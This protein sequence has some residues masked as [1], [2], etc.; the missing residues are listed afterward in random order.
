MQELLGYLVGTLII[1][2][3]TASLL[4][5]LVFA[6]PGF[7]GR[8][9]NTLENLPGRAFAVGLVNFIFF[10]LIAAIA[11]QIGDSIGDFVG[12]LFNLSAL[13]ILW[14][15]LLL[16]SVG[17]A[18]FLSRLIHG[19]T[20]PTVNQTWRMGFLLVLAMLTP[21]IGWFIIGPII[22][23]TGMGAVILTLVL[24]LRSSQ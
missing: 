20:P 19:K 14:V 2:V 8:L 4:A 22:F 24:Q 7:M 15:L 5:I 3:T 13:C 16:M 9:R 1:S 23:V 11:S 17:M 6:M 10:T 21:V 18:G 12:G